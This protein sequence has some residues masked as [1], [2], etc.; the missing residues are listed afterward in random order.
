MIH[1]KTFCHHIQK[2]EDMLH[3]LII[4]SGGTSEDAKNDILLEFP[5]STADI[6]IPAGE[7]KEYNKTVKKRTKHISFSVP[8]GCILTIT[9]DNT[10]LCWFSGEQG[11]IEYN[12]Y[13]EE[14]NVTCQNLTEQDQQWRCIILVYPV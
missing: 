14:L 9:V 6:V 13:I 2:I 7:T 3:A 8:Q 12:G 5:E 10:V 4:A 1:E 11:S